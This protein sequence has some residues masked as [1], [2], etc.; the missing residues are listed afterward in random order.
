VL[1]GGL[2][3]SEGEKKTIRERGVLGRGVDSSWAGLV[4][5][6][7]FSYFFLLLSFSFSVFFA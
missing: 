3:L 4:A 6:G 2:H 7:S 5:P 1:T